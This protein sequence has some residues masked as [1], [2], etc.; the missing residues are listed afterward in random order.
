MLLNI[1]EFRENRRRECR[2]QN[3]SYARAV[4]PCDILKVQNRFKSFVLRHE[5][6]R[7]PSSFL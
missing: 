4:R 7:L 6:H 3:Y 5:V 1:C 2:K